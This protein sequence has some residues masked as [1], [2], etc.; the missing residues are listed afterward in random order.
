MAVTAAC[1]DITGSSRAMDVAFLEDGA[2]RLR[3]ESNVNG[4]LNWVSQH[5]PEIIAIDAPS[6]ENSG[7]VPRLRQKYSIPDG[8]YDNFRIAEVLLKLK[9]IGLYNTPQKQ[10]PDWMKRGWDLYS[11]LRGIGFGVVESPG[12]VAAPPK[13][14]IEVHPH[15]SFVVGLGWIPQSKRTLAGQLERAAYLRKECADLTLTCE[16]TPLAVDQLFLLQGVSSAWASIVTDGIDL[17]LLS[18]DQL[19]AMVGL[20]TAVRSM[21]GEAIA[22]GDPGDGVIVV[23][24]QLGDASYKRKH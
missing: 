23:P 7:C 2:I 21:Q 9:G 14:V 18:H 17:P 10:P 5:Q 3:I 8:R 11:L 15:A 22:V 19:D 24:R 4:F 12:K 20:T 6:K 1:I 16:G 13:S